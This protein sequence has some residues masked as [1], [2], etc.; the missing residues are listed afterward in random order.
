VICIDSVRGDSSDPRELIREARAMG[1]LNGDRIWPGYS[2]APFGVL[3]V[4]E[5]RERLF[6]HDGPADGF[7]SLGD[8]PILSC[9]SSIRQA[10]FPPNLL[11]SFPAVDG[12]ATIVIGL[13]EATE[14][15]ADAWVLTILHEHFHQAQFSWPD[16]YSGTEN[17]GLSRGDETGMW[18]LDYPFPYDRDVTSLAFRVMADR[19]I[20]VLSVRG[21]GAFYDSLLQYWQARESARRTVSEDDWRYVELQLWQ[22]GV[23]RWTESAIAALSDG[24]SDAAS[25]ANERIMRELSDLDLAKRGRAAVYP[26]GAGEAML[27]E[28][29][30]S[31]WRDRYWI[32]PFS[33]GP[34]LKRLVEKNQ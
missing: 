5:E 26:I 10:T 19:L 13:P 2:D 17:L 14:L 27:L 33:L 32:E 7:E 21:T 31:D 11:A 29:A 34:Q 16:Y 1:E 18:M 24:Y 8:D 28:A 4:E 23:A 3:L 15:S 12:I 25:E 6:C 30:G 9:S 22:E 20:E